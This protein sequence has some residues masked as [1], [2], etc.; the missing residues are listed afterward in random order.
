M[1]IHFQL[2]MGFLIILFRV[3]KRSLE[4]V[5]WR[6]ENY[7]KVEI[8]NGSNS[9]IIYSQAYISKNGAAWTPITLEGINK[10]GE[11]II[12]TATQKLD[13]TTVELSSYNYIAAMIC[14][15]N[16]TS[17]ACGCSNAICTGSTGGMWNLQ[18]LGSMN[19]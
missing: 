17:F 2:A 9:V 18:L 7:A 15:Q 11:W 10:S 12:G 4:G 3:I 14:I 1:V 5:L 16:G 19:H 8:G 6:I 13:L